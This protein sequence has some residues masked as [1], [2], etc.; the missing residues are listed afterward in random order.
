MPLIEGALFYFGGE[1]LKR[2]SKIEMD[3]LL[4]EITS[5]STVLSM[6]GMCKNAGK[7]T[8][9]NAVLSSYEEIDTLRF[10][11]L[12]IGLDGEKQDRATNGAKPEIHVRENTLFI[13]P[14]RMWRESDVSKELLEILPS[15]GALGSLLLV[16]SR[17]DGK[18]QLS[19]PSS[20]AALQETIQHLQRNGADKILIDGSIHRRVLGYSE[21]GDI[22]LCTALSCF[23]DPNSAL[24]ETVFLYHLYTELPLTSLHPAVH[25]HLA[26][27]D[28]TKII[29][30]WQADEVQKEAF[31]WQLSRTSKYNGILY[32]GAVTARILIHLRWLQKHRS[33]RI[34]IIADGS[35]VVV[36]PT[37]WSDFLTSGIE[38]FVQKKN[39]VKAIFVNHSRN[40]NSADADFEF[41][42][43]IADRVQCPVIDW[44]EE[45]V[46]IQK[47]I[48]CY[49]K[50]K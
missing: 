24:R 41:M 25:S 7:T 27:F 40:A 38:V 43:Q 47:K 44:K 16:R 39:N 3:C 23:Q 15:G 22:L 28:H 10:G 29:Q 48:E 18:I 13:T 37:M 21:Q 12:S 33:L 46:C 6:V 5:T 36:S 45:L 49:G 2:L 17:S 26:V 31:D 9:L 32:R 50:K 1:G 4:R 11:L 19:G 35:R 8:I 20:R 42:Q 14:S 34:L 30:T